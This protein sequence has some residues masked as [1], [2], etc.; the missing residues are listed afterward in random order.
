MFHVFH[1]R[2]QCLNNNAHWFHRNGSI[3]KIPVCCSDAHWAHSHCY[4]AHCRQSKSIL[5]DSLLLASEFLDIYSYSNATIAKHPLSIRLRWFRIIIMINLEYC[6][7]SSSWYCGWCS[8]QNLQWRQQAI[9]CAC[10]PWPWEPSQR[11]WHRRPRDVDVIKRNWRF[12]PPTIEHQ[13][14]LSGYC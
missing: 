6:S 14:L 12:G 7:E 3:A 11:L 4:N 5:T 2:T 10:R 13:I 9:S 1:T 8:N